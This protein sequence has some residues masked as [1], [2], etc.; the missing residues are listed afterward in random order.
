MNVGYALVALASL[1]LTTVQC[2]S[3]GASAAPLYAP[4]YAF[5]YTGFGGYHTL[6]TISSISAR[7]KVPAINK[8]S[9]AGA[10]ATWI[11]AQNNR[12]NVFIQVGILENASK[13]GSDSY[14]AFWSDTAKGFRPQVWGNLAAGDLISV[15]MV[16]T[17][18]G[19]TVKF[20]DKSA[21]LSDVKRIDYGVGKV[22]NVGE[23]IQEDPS[24]ANIT[25]V[26]LSYPNIANAK[27]N[28]VRVN[29]HAPTLDGSDAQI[30]IAKGGIIRVPTNFASDSFSFKRPT[31]L[32]D[33]YLTDAS[34]FDVGVNLFNAD[35]ARWNTTS[36]TGKKLAVQIYVNALKTNA[37]V[38]TSQTWPK[39]TG[40]DVAKLGMNI[41]QVESDLRSWLVA[42]AKNSGS[43]YRQLGQDENVHH[44]LVDAV[45]TSLGLP[46]L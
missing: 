31:G 6:A 4:T 14:Q 1:T 40:V 38:F 5:P 12:D 37:R 43:A 29:G 19:W 7:W 17:Q 9:K 44:T 2:G 32:Q 30:L 41:R 10:A 3:S 20:E 26:D 21:K 45:R 8:H 33:Q 46:P 28:R 27:I 42:G 39:E 35:Y 24:P 11:G 22:F 18:K 13:F 25:A 16:R 36:K 15:E 23:W 34:N